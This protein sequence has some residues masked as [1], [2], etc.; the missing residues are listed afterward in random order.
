MVE[1]YHFK[2]WN[3]HKGDWE[4][5]PSKRTA[6]G[7]LEAKGEIIPDTAEDVD[8]TLIDS[9]GRF[10]PSGTAVQIDRPVPDDR[11][12]RKPK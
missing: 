3:I 1:V 11:K 7:I 5:P 2:V 6:G 12:K 10:F 4:V 8:P 9:Q